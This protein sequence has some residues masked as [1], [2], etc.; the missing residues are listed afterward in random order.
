M[1]DVKGRI[2]EEVSCHWVIENVADV[3]EALKAATE[4]GMYEVYAICLSRIKEV[5]KNEGKRTWYKA[6][7]KEERIGEADGTTR[8]PKVRKVTYQ[9]LAQADDLNEASRFLKS[10]LEQGYDFEMSGLVETDIY[11]VL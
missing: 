6:T 7:I 11:D 4:N 3:A 10:Q 2:N 8:P 1:Y 9:V 5:F